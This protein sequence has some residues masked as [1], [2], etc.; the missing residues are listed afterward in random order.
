MHLQIQLLTMMPHGKKRIHISKPF[1]KNKFS[2]NFKSTYKSK[3]SF[4]LF[5]I[6]FRNKTN[7]HLIL[8]ALH[9]KFATNR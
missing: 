5:K 2:F 4:N 1:E 6:G 7:Q 8:E 3:Q 9:C